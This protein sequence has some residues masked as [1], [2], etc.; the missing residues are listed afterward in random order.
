[1]A[2]GG[3]RPKA[4]DEKEAAQWLRT[5]IMRA[6]RARFSTAALALLLL[7]IPLGLVA[8]NLFTSGMMSLTA[9]L[10]VHRMLLIRLVPSLP[11][12][13]TLSLAS[14]ISSTPLRVATAAPIFGVLSVVASFACHGQ[15][16]MACSS[17]L[18]SEIASPSPE[19][20][21]PCPS[22][23]ALI[24]AAWAATVGVVATG[25][26]L[27]GPV[28]MWR[29]RWPLL[30]QHS[31]LRLRRH[32]RPAAAHSARTAIICAVCFTLVKWFIS[33]RALLAVGA[34]LLSVR[35]GCS[36]EVSEPTEQAA[37]GGMADGFW[38]L[39]R[40]GCFFF[41]L[42][43]ALHAATIAYSQA[44]PFTAAATDRSDRTDGEAALRLALSKHNAPMTQHLAFLDVFILS[45]CA[46]PVR[47]ILCA[48]VAPA[49]PHPFVL[50]A[51]PEVRSQGMHVI[52]G[53][54]AIKGPRHVANVAP[55]ANCCAACVTGTRHCG[56]LFSLARALA[57]AHMH[58]L[59][60][61]HPSA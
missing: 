8:G 19:G 39:L 22:S 16:L 20:G 12:A 13:K 17:Q 36:P 53:P 37:V 14:Y 6:D 3:I 1:M 18:P 5:L 25:Q 45:E 44:L 51:R 24:S 40:A 50:A 33:R 21:K 58:P 35:C 2:T 7:H 30:Q 41:S 46:A 55:P 11:S 10:I 43:V 4:S 15:P 23:L 29:L 47:G 59:L 9:L 56:A 52:K 60:Q 34:A 48:A 57:Q 26:Y 38:L 54:K 32:L 42:N 49:S 31:L 28:A 27:F 61:P